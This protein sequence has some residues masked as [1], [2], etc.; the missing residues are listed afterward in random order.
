M[1]FITFDKEVELAAKDRLLDMMMSKLSSMWREVIQP[2]YLEFDYISCGEMKISDSTFRRIK[3]EAIGILAST[4][5]LE[6]FGSE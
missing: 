3:S 2:S 1:L 4:L 5:K 6:V